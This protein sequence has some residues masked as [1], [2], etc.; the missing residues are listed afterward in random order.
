MS[1]SNGAHAHSAARDLVTRRCERDL[2]SDR[3]RSIP[4]SEPQ[5]D[6]DRTTVSVDFA[7]SRFSFVQFFIYFFNFL[8]LVCKVLMDSTEPASQSGV[9]CEN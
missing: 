7:F 9:W 5:L 2:A 8:N 4:P 1:D 3:E 6:A